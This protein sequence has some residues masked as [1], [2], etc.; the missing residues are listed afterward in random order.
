MSDTET[1]KPAK[2]TAARKAH[3]TKKKAENAPAEPRHYQT[4]LS[5]VVTEKSTN[6]SQHNQVTFRVPL[7]A[8]K[9]QIAAAVEALFKVKVRSVNTLVVKGKLKHFRGKF[10]LR[11]DWKKAVVRLAEGAT[12]DLTASV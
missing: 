8:T 11:S 10:A 6:G 7:D 2:A 3:A 12:I 5:P 9:P 4:I 1:K